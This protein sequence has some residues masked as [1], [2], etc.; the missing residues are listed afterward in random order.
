MT[1]TSTRSALGGAL[2]SPGAPGGQSKG[3]HG[4]LDL[5]D[6]VTQKTRDGLFTTVGEQ[7]PSIRRNPAAGS[8]DLLKKVFGS[9]GWRIER[10]APLHFAG[11]T[12]SPVESH[13]ED[14]A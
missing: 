11:M 7:E 14:D 3:G 13:R 8:S 12:R 9:H 4:P 10:V 6:C 2:G 5:D 1:A